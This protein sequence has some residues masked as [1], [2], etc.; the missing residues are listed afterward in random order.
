V[1]VDHLRGA[2]PCRRA[3]TLPTPASAVRSSTAGPEPT[4][5]EST[6]LL[7]PLQMIGVDLEVTQEAGRIRRTT[8]TKLPDALIAAAALLTR[9][10]LV[11]R[12]VK[13]FRK[14]TG[15]RLR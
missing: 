2:D 11:T 7:D 3:R 1:L 14:V 8:R 15:L 10:H 12:N 6:P 13:D 4:R 5:S 9:R